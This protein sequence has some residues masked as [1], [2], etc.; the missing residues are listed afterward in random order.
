MIK[1]VCL[2][3]G[4]NR[5]LTT[6]T[7]GLLSLHPNC[8]VLNHGRNLLRQSDCDFLQYPDQTHLA[9]FCDAAMDRS[10]KKTHGVKGGTILRSHAFRPKYNLKRVYTERFGKSYMKKDVKC[11]V[12]K[13]AKFITS[14]IR[15]HQIDL[16][17]VVEKC[18]SLRF[19]LPIRNPMD[20]AIS[21]CKKT[22]E[23]PLDDLPRVL[24]TLEWG[25]ELQSRLPQIIDLW[26]Q[27][28]QPDTITNVG[29]F[30]H[31]PPD[32]RWIADV[33][34]CLVLNKSHKH[35]ESLQKRY[36]EEIE[37]RF[38][39]QNEVLAAFQTFN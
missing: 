19:I 34:K 18:E 25:L 9:A 21:H 20:C 31:L 22:N 38:A 6:L 11:L 2:L 33:A 14:Y 24:D 15:K 36:R 5:N 23:D 12:W 37:L 27:A 26:E 10:T 29:Q 28:F 1:T 16:S 7:A 30:L 13:D 3:L 39:S 35:T 8:Q 32:D 17:E 4:P